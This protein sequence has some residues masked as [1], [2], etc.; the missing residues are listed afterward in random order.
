MPATR[1]GGGGGGGGGCGGWKG[2]KKAKWTK[3]W[4]EAA[5]VEV[6]A[7]KTQ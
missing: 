1:G 5:A 6:R 4:E 3:Q 7:I 2:K